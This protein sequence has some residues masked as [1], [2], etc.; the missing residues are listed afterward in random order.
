[1]NKK[2]FPLEEQTLQEIKGNSNIA[3]KN[4]SQEDARKLLILDYEIMTLQEIISSV[5]YRNK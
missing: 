2:L 1:M 5:V 4:Y 3:V